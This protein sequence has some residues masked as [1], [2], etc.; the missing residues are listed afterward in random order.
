MRPDYSRLF[1]IPQTPIKYGYD[2]F[3][4]ETNNGIFFKNATEDALTYYGYD[5]DDIDS[6]MW[7]M[8]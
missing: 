3:N 2:E 6:Y 4:A 5:N 7:P 1:D 8:L